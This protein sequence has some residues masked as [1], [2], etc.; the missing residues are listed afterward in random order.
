M[1]PADLSKLRGPVLAG[2][3]PNDAVLVGPE[4]ADDAGVYLL[5]DEAVVATADFITPMCDDARRFGRVAAANALSDVYAMGGSVLFALNL[6]CFPEDAAPEGTLTAI[7]EG[8]LEKI[9][10][11]GGALLGGHSVRDAEL[12]YGLAVV[13]RADPKRLLTNAAARPGQHLVLTKPLG[14]GAI[15]NGFRDG[16]LDAA[17]LEPALNGMERLNDVAARLALEHQV[18]GCTDVTGYGLAGHALEMARASA[19]TL[20]LKVDALPVYAGFQR[21]CELCVSTRGARENEAAVTDSVKGH[22]DLAPQESQLLFDPQTSGGLLLSVGEATVD[23]LLAELAA[24]GH[25]AASIG[26]VVEG[27]PMLRVT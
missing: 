20:E 2:G 9:H 26:M 1:G 7:L 5:G 16:H 4:T 23:A 18:T 10:E 22:G 17:G 11:A 13:G 21:M 27:P 8:G 25:E 24:T 3:S 15:I 12:K 19:V 14:T 6:C